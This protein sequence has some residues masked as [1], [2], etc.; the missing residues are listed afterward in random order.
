MAI[1]PRRRSASFALAACA[2]LTLWYLSSLTDVYAPTSLSNAPQPGTKSN[3]GL[4]HWSKTKER[5]PVESF[6]PLPSGPPHQLPKLQH[7]FATESEQNKS[8]REERLAAVKESFV[9]TWESY[10]ASAWMRD[11]LAP[12]T[13]GYL[14]TFGGWAATLVDTLDTLWIM[15]L[16]DEM[17]IAVEAAAEI[18]FTNT[19]SDM[20]NVFETTIRYL[21]GFLG[22]YDLS[23][24]KYPVLLEKAKEL[25]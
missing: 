22:A 2:I 12:V 13:G 5:Y 17:K 10:K 9:H 18:D 25:G 20:L 21:G 3:D 4:L 8:T 23:D 7:A 14:T 6:L 1:L 16:D 19:E 24:S 11:E 15:G